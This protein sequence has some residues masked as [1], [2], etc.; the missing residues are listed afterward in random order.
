MLGWALNLGFAGS[1]TPDAPTVPTA[2]KVAYVQKTSPAS[3]G[4]RWRTTAWI[5]LR[6][7]WAV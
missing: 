4:T 3:W 1:G 2:T 7:S 5:R 6:P